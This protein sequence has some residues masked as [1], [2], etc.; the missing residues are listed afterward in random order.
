[1]A[2]VI[3]ARAGHRRHGAAWPSAQR[4]HGLGRSLACTFIRGAWRDKQRL[5]TLHNAQL[6]PGRSSTLSRTGSELRFAFAFERP[7]S[8]TLQPNEAGVIM[9][10]L[11]LKGEAVVRVSQDT[12]R[13]WAS[14]S[15]VEITQ[16]STEKSST[17][18]LAQ[19]YFASGRPR[20][21]SLFRVEYGS[22]WDAPVLLFSEEGQ[23]MFDPKGLRQAN[24][25]IVLSWKSASSLD[26]PASLRYGTI[27]NGF[28]LQT[29]R[30]I[31]PVSLWDDVG[32]VAPAANNP[33]WLSREPEKL[34]AI[35]VFSRAGDE[36]VSA[37]HVNVP[38]AGA[39]VTVGSR[40]NHSILLISAASNP[41]SQEAPISTIV[42]EVIVQCKRS[43]R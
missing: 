20:S 37:G 30:P 35:R 36:I 2:C 28:P 41:S 17:V 12:M 40:K 14:P 25:T 5:T 34:N 21:Q 42:T 31:A 43:T 27:T 24:G 11:H 8:D 13:T 39:G 9:M 3:R 4:I 38:V 23:Q 22:R 18:L 29:F 33:V 1:M 16:G 15:Y 26:A 6:S 7:V 19:P 32:F 10:R